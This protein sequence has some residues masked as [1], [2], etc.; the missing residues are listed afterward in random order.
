M[1]K[2]LKR[3]VLVTLLLTAA[4][5]VV[6]NVLAVPLEELPPPDPAMVISMPDGPDR[7]LGELVALSEQ[8]AA[9]GAVRD[10][11]RRLAARKALTDLTEVMNGGDESQGPDP[12]ELRAALERWKVDRWAVPPDGSDLMEL[13]DYKRDMGEP[14][15]AAALLRSI[16]DDHPQYA[17][18][19]RKLGWNIYADDLGDPARGVAFVNLS[20]KA[21][22]FEGNAWQDAVRVYA[23]GLGIDID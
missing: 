19:M 13:A 7:T 16:P 2:V 17:R 20:L 21:D 18:A 14:E 8:A 10:E 3:L 9:E 5:I 1:F 23:G 15:E 11:A 22:P 12:E 4:G 6:V